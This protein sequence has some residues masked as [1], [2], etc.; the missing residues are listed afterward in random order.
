M[1]EKSVKSF[2][3]FFSSRRRHTRWTGDLSSDVC[4]S[5]L[6]H[7]DHIKDICFLVENTFY[8]SRA[9][10]NLRSTPEILT[11]VHK[12]MLNDILWPDFSKIYV[13]QAQTKCLIKFQPIQSEMEFRGLKIRHCG[14]NHPGNAICYLL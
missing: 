6:A 11:S 3:F 14:V 5:D 8:E 2:C 9:V 4:S 13:D 1:N 7:I 10:I 12:H